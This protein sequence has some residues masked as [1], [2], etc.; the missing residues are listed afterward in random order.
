MI[1][2]ENATDVVSVELVEEA[3]KSGAKNATK[4]GV[5]NMSYANAKAA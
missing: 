3:S 4:N 2:S 1:L 5:T